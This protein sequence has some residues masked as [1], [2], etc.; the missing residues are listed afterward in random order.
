MAKMPDDFL[1]GVE[2]EAEQKRNSEL[3]IENYSLK[4]RLW[5]LERELERLTGM[6][7]SARKR[8]I[9]EA[10]AKAASEKQTLDHL[11]KIFEGQ[12]A[13]LEQQMAQALQ[14]V[15]EAEEEA[16]RKEVQALKRIVEAEEEARRKEAATKSARAVL[17]AIDD[18]LKELLQVGAEEGYRLA[19]IDR[20]G[21][22]SP[23]TS[24]VWCPP[25]LRLRCMS[26]QRDGG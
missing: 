3:S 13:K 4:E 16:G 19:S 21:K 22:R 9:D 11:A 24:A 12:K 20:G 1:A 7:P 10:E 8:V 26:F 25:V 6:T 14:R 17:E 18:N 5:A 15:A 23:C 2:L